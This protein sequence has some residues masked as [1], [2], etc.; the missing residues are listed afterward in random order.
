MTY[1]KGGKASSGS[2]QASNALY[3]PLR[4]SESHLRFS[5]GNAFPRTGSGFL[6]LLQAI[7][8]SA[9]ASKLGHPTSE[10]EPTQLPEWLRFGTKLE[11]EW[12]DGPRLQSTTQDRT[13][14]LEK[15]AIYS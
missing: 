5:E 6:S 1:H 7:L 9:E 11:Q 13:Y 14:R 4:V 15:P 2:L 8:R 3:W 12:V 10:F